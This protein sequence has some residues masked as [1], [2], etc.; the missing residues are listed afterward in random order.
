[1]SQLPRCTVCGL[2][3]KP[4]GRSI[5]LDATYC[6]S[7][8]RGFWLDPQPTT[9]WPHEDE[10]K[11]IRRWPCGT[12]QAMPSEPYGWLSDDFEVVTVPLDYEVGK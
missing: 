4:L 8:C 3:K 9:Y 12:E 2:S 11:Q 5:P 10:T 6:L 1:M 7:T